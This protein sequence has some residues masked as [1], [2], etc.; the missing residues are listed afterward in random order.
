MLPLP[1][2]LS[3]HYNAMLERS[4]V[5]LT[6]R[7]F[8]RKWL[9]YYLDFCHNYHFDQS[10]SNSFSAFDDK[11]RQKSQ[12]QSLRKQAYH[13][14]SLYHKI[15][16]A[17]NNC[18]IGNPCA[19]R[20]NPK[21]DDAGNKPLRTHRHENRAA[22]V[23]APFAALSSASPTIFQPTVENSSSIPSKRG[24]RGNSYPENRPAKA[25]NDHAFEPQV[26]EQPTARDV[27]V[28]QT[29]ASWEWVFTKLESAIKVRHYSPKTLKAYRTWTQKLQAYVKSKD[30]SLLGMDDVRGFLSFLAVEKNVSASSQNQAFNALL[31]LFRHILE[32]DF[33]RIEGVVR[34]KRK[35][36][37]PVVLSREEV[38]RVLSQ[39]S[40]P[41][42]LV[43]KLLYGCG[44]RLSECLKLRVQDLNFDMQVVTVHDGKGKKDRTVPLP[45]VLMPELQSQ[46]ETVLQIQWIMDNG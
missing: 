2:D 11:L 1:P 33:E 46:L 15:N 6:H 36:Y 7:P 35:P 42:D 4:G 27:D 10:D 45:E 8:Y 26:P 34:A 19:P 39:L 5:A 16:S 20:A 41:Y 14:V 12:P 18:D 29:G 40:N 25:G 37:I 24:E 44:L 31:F 32:K 23:N 38:D 28:H 13:A 30:P 9:R 21:L 3:R 43:G 17:A 22:T